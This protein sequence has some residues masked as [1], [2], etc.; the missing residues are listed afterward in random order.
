MTDNTL[1]S[2][3]MAMRRRVLGSAY[4]DGQ[5]QRTNEFTRSLQD[6]VVRY[7]W[8]EVWNRPAITPRQRSLLTVSM[9]I[10]LDRPDEL[11]IHVRGALNNGCTVDELEETLIQAAIYCGVPAA[12]G[13]CRVVQD[14]LQHDS[15]SSDD[16]ANH[17]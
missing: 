3:G 5:V 9:L 14:V 7:C 15:E 13:A 4:V 2:S 8:G 1:H 12:L 6:L 10:A 16:Q 17:R 11:R